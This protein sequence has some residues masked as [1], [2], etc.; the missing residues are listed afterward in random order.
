MVLPGLALHERM[1]APD[2]MARAQ[3]AWASLLT[4]RDQRG[5]RQHGRTLAD[6]A[7]PIAVERRDGY[8]ERDPRAL[9]E[10]I[11]ARNRAHARFDMG[12]PHARSVWPELWQYH[13]QSEQY[14]SVAMSLEYASDQLTAAVRSLATSD[15]GLAQRLQTAWDDHVQMVW[16]KPCLTRDLLREFRDLWHHYTAPSDD[17]Q[18]T[19]LRELTRD[20][21]VMAIGRLVSL[22]NKVAVAAATLGDTQLATLADLA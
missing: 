7:L 22:A 19:K 12:L 17:R 11:K 15:D 13:A 6:A 9:F 20:E 2:F 4:D 8:V 16:M 5:E 10:R 1:E 3:A 14:G 21:S 18:S